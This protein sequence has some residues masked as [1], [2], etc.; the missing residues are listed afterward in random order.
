MFISQVFVSGPIA[1]G[2]ASTR[3]FVRP[4]M[5]NPA[6]IHRR[7]ASIH[8]YGYRDRGL[9]SSGNRRTA[10][11]PERPS[12]PRNHQLIVNQFHVIINSAAWNLS[13]IH[14]QNG[15]I[16]HLGRREPTVQLPESSDNHPTNRRNHPTAST[17]L[18]I[19]YR[20]IPRNYRSNWC[21][22]SHSSD[23]RYLIHGSHQID[24]SSR[25]TYRS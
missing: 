15:E 2:F 19:I 22:V 25:F 13:P 5:R 7:F 20:R 11:H 6:I 17:K 12:G 23:K 1:C 4:A 18:P 8:R 10:P 3:I 21:R 24:M 9:E 16:Y 14:H